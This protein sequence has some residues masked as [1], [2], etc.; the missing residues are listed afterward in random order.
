MTARTSA[1]AA[2]RDIIRAGEADIEVLSQVIADA[3]FPLAPCEWLIPDQAAR[4][5][6]FPG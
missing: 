2:A 3:F 6:I 5:A 4:R 1:S